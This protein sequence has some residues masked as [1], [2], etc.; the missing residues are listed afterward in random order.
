MVSMKATSSQDKRLWLRREMILRRKAEFDR[1][2]RK[3]FRSVGRMISVHVIPNDL[4]HCRLGM[5]V[6]RA[7]GGAVLRNRIRRQLRE[8]FR[9]NQ[10]SFP[11]A[12][13]IVIVPRRPWRSPAFN[14]IADEFVKVVKKT[15]ERRAGP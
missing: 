1:A 13:D 4:G 3:G 9:L 15:L 11:V 12:C 6:S 14:E 5:A 10:H 7:V 2:F 8:A